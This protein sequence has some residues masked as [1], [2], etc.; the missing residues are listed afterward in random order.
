MGPFHWTVW[1]AL[2]FAYM[3]A[4]L[5]LVFSHSFSL[6]IL[7][8]S[9]GQIENMFWYVFGTFTNLFTFK[10]RDSWTATGRTSTRMIIGELLCY[11]LRVGSAW[12]R[13]IR[14]ACRVVLGVLHHRHRLLHGLHHL[15]HRVPCLSDCR[16]PPLATVGR[17]LPGRDT[18]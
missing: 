15:L 16:R 1:L 6:T 5:P 11:T 7:I 12:T 3:F 2:T 4:I 14:R 8:K 13:V 18:W 9:P 17:Q 10:G